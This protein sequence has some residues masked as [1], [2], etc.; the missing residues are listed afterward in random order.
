LTFFCSGV[1]S[2][3]KKARGPP[4]SLS[5]ILDNWDQEDVDLL[6]ARSRSSASI[7]SRHSMDIDD[8]TTGAG[9]IPSDDDEIEHKEL[10]TAVQNGTCFRVRHLFFLKTPFLLTCL[11]VSWNC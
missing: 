7:A 11:L 2:K 4:P 9:G 5:G 3:V 1:A 10:K 6:P 8:L